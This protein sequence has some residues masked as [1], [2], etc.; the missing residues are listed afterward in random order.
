MGFSGVMSAGCVESQSCSKRDGERQRTTSKA[1]E[2]S[3]AECQERQ[4]GR[5]QRT[6]PRRTSQ[7]SPPLNPSAPP[8]S[9]RRIPSKT[10]P[11]S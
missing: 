5:T 8:A 7:N 10:P 9:P 11:T 4:T 1:G 2:M 3:N 6:K